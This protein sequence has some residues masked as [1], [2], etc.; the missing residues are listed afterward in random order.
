MTES[1][2]SRLINRSRQ[3][4]NVSRERSQGENKYEHEIYEDRPR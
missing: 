2:E 4:E 3:L 1:R